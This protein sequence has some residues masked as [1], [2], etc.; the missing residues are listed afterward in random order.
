MPVMRCPPRHERGHGRENPCLWRLSCNRGACLAHISP[1]TNRIRRHFARIKAVGLDSGRSWLLQ[2]IEL[3]IASGDAQETFKGTLRRPEADA[4][5][6]S[7]KK[8]RTFRRR[9]SGHFAS[10]SQDT[11]GP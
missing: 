8:V 4:Q 2:Q 1:L 6:I 7:K 3:Q 10:E 5:D 9:K 11:S